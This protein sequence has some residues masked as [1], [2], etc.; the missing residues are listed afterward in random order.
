MDKRIKRYLKNDISI[1]RVSGA[2]SSAGEPQYSP[3]VIYKG[4][5]EQKE[6]RVTDKLG[7]EVISKSRIFL[8]EEAVV[9]L[10]DLVMLPSGNEYPV[11]KVYVKRN[12]SGEVDH[13]MVYI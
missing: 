11:I 4:K 8:D 12:L 6:T 3:A 9:E 13:I 1:K 2:F 7:R 10:D 5:L